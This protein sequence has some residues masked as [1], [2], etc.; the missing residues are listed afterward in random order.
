MPWNPKSFK[1]ISPKLHSSGLFL[2]GCRSGFLISVDFVR[3]QT[4]IYQE[5]II[6]FYPVSL[7]I[8]FLFHMYKVPICHVSMWHSA[9]KTQCNSVCFKINLDSIRLKFKTSYL[10]SDRF[11][12]SAW[13][14]AR[15][16]WREDNKSLSLNSVLLFLL[17]FLLFL[18][19]LERQQCFGGEQKS[20]RGASLPP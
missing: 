13:L 4:H 16:I 5:R 9:R 15:K 6:L 18:K 3:C 7:Q 1:K 10:S 17:F 11:G 8:D 19:I 12:L 2:D 20:F 14:S